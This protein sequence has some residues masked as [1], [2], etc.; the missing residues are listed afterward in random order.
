LRSGYTGPT[1]LPSELSSFVGREGELEQTKKLLAGSRL[2]TLTGVGGVGKTRLALKLAADALTDHPD[3]VWWLELA[4]LRDPALVAAMLMAV[5]GIRPLP[6]QSETDAAVSYLSRRQALV[7]LDN[8]EHLLDPASWLVEVLLRGCPR[9]RVLATSRQTLGVEGETDW[10]VPSLSLA[11]DADQPSMDAAT[12]D[13]A[14][15]FVERAAQAR[16]GFGVSAED[17]SAVTGI[18]RAL[19]GIPLA[20]E[21]AAARVRV[22]SVQQI[23]AGVADSLRLL[24]RG[25]RTRLPRQQTLRASIDWSH[26]LL[27]DRERILFRRVGVFLG[28]FTLE[29]A[30]QICADEA[31]P[32]REVLDVLDALV[33]KSLA[34]SDQQ[35]SE[36][37]YR[38]LEPVR[39]YA[40]ERLAAAGEEEVLRYR[41]RDAYLAVAERAVARGFGPGI[42]QPSV[43]A[44][45]GREAANLR[46]AF[47]HALVSDGERALRLAVAIA[48]WW[49]A[50]GHFQE[51]DDAFARALTA[52][53][54]GRSLQRALALSAR[55][56]V[57]ANTGAHLRA[58][59]YGEQA[60]AVAEGLGDDA[61]LTGALLAMGAAQVYSEPRVAVQALK[62]AR[63]LADGTGDEWATARC[64]TLIGMAAAS[65]QDPDLHREHTEGLAARLEQLGDLETLGLYWIWVFD[66]AYA[67][68]D[69]ARARN[70]CHRALQAGRAI[71][72]PTQYYAGLEQARLLDTATG[73][74]SAAVAELRSIQSIA[75]ERGLSVIPWAVVSRA[76]AEGACGELRVAATELELLLDS[77]AGGACDPL[78]W[79]TST[80]AEVLRLQG[81]DRAEECARRGLKLARSVDNRFR[82][83]SNQLTLGRLAAARGDWAEAEQLH[84]EALGTIIERGYRLELPRALEALAEVACGLESHPEAARILGAADR[85]RR[86]L[87]L[88]P[89]P[90]QRAE[91]DALTTRLRDTL[92]NHSLENARSEGAALSEAEALAW[93]RRGRGER[94]RPTHGWES[95]TPTE[96]EVARHLAA[97]LTNPQIATKMFV[98]RSTVKTH[99]A[100]IYTK[101]GTTSRAQLAIEAER[102][103]RPRQPDT[104]KP[105]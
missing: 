105:S 52:A 83:A 10:R 101:L 30:E 81:D 88:V 97:G 4:P 16:P 5:L 77:Q 44:T 43:L 54:S 40:L 63:E 72:S 37:R 7:V 51:A 91:R 14:R 60:V 39:Q 74:A 90:A 53:T 99:L 38:L 95:L 70:A 45:L 12:S 1:N 41:H 13:A 18:C 98:S 46:V 11:A 67:A 94:R 71:D 76:T 22:L 23:A 75:I 24:S 65:C 58:K 102:R 50:R 96:L 8:C 48:P 84:H 64:R 92:G 93:I 100:H 21:L 82:A 80:L 56:W 3:G 29:A 68:G 85:A 55:A 57:I 17:V 27:G 34:Q 78:V 31:L 62:R 33:E 61:V 6:G 35:G 89:W 26:D 49:R 104:A 79:A 20:L 73:N 32:V 2:L 66:L 59:G 103:V 25:A 86:T 42:G 87:G 19:D 47:E 36:V 9:L 28:G 15:L 69:V